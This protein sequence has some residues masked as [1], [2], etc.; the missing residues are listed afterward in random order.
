MANDVSI[1][2]CVYA[3]TNGLLYICEEMNASYISPSP[4]PR[5]LWLG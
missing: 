3:Q 4:S 5:H 1:A 2:V